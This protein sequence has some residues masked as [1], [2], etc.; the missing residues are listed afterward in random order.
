MMNS[1]VKKLNDILCVCSIRVFETH[2]CSCQ[3]QHAD[4]TVLHTRTHMHTHQI[5]LTLYYIHTHTH[6]HTTHT[7][8]CFIYS[9]RLSWEVA[10]IALSL[11]NP[12]LFESPKSIFLFPGLVSHGGNIKRL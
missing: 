3:H 1:K 7:K 8:D 4:T 2:L 11:S 5:L 6:I 10:A 12:E 9:T